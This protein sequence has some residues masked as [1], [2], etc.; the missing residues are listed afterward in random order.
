MQRIGVQLVG[1]PANLHPRPG[2]RHD[3][4]VVRWLWWCWLWSLPVLADE[5]NSDDHRWRLSAV[6]TATFN[7]DEGFGFGGVV[8]LYHDHQGIKP[9]R[10]A[11][12]FNLFI[13]TKLI[14]AHAITWDGIRPF[15]LPGR[16]YARLGYFSTVSQNYCGV[17]NAVDCSM[18]DALARADELQLDDA[19][20]LSDARDDYLRRFYL[21]RFIRPFA[22]LIGRYWLRDKPYRT[23]VMVGWR[24]S[25]TWPGDIFQ[26][27]P[28]PGSRYADDFPDGEQGLSSVPF[29]GLIVDDRDD[30]VFPTRGMYA[31]TSVR[32]AQPWT[33]SQWPY[34]GANAVLA[35]F[36]NVMPVEW[37][38]PGGPRAVLATR[39]VA[40]VLV[41]SP[42][43]EEMARIG[44]TLDYIAFG[45]GYLGRGIREHRY[46]GKVKLIGQAEV[47]T[48]LWQTK[49]WGEG[50]DL[51]AAVFSDVAAIGYDLSDWRGSPLKVLPTIGVSWRIL[52]NE[53]FAIRWDLATSPAEA[54]GPGFYI[55]VG[56]AF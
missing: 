18:A 38:R 44:G 32:V 52:W 23:E 22:T 8:S 26:R 27:G 9:Y 24:G 5:D 33:G 45:G 55:I 35:G 37:Q 21:M 43:I 13:S 48:Q 12:T 31:E 6:P 36:F 42:S 41:G 4:R 14:Q 20:Y 51:G 7:T 2:H 54:E 29:V 30:E 50:F 39:V 10:D 3:G 15:G 47:R 16:I 46:L 11:L 19:P 40:D 28:Y 34:V 49:L 1:R 17:G 25:Y 53:T 56:Q